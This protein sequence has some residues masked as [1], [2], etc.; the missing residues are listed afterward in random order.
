MEEPC[1]TGNGCIDHGG[2][3]SASHIQ[4]TSDKEHGAHADQSCIVNKIKMPELFVT[5]K[6]LHASEQR[7]EQKYQ[8]AQPDQMGMKIR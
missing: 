7:E 1:D 4:D 8:A 2:E 5:G 3:F 6:V